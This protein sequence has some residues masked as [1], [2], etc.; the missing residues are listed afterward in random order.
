MSHNNLRV[1][2]LEEL[3]THAGTIAGGIA[4]SDAGIVSALSLA[5]NGFSDRLKNVF[6]LALPVPASA[7]T[8]D[9]SEFGITDVSNV[10][11][12]ECE[13]SPWIPV[14]WWEVRNHRLSI[15]GCDIAGCH[16]AQVQIEHWERPPDY[17]S[18]SGTLTVA[19]NYANAN[20]GEMHVTLADTSA[21]PPS[22]YVR[23]GESPDAQWFEYQAVYLSADPITEVTLL[24]AVKQPWA[25]QTGT[26]FTGEIVEWG[27]GF[28]SSTALD[29]LTKQAASYYWASKTGQC[30]NNDDR[31][32]ALN[33]LNFWT[34]EA[35]NAW[36]QVRPQRKP[37][38]LKKPYPGED[39][40]HSL[41]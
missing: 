41:Y 38:I 3:A 5:L 9:L 32:A 4:P 20:G 31:S 8:L 19:F 30:T 36:R 22:G 24:L 17:P 26:A 21:L 6:Y 33:L 40:C 13:S 10:W 37:V 34:G 25:H 1:L 11:W 35:Q 18:T 7:H 27:L 16:G 23:V 29:A 14:K 28:P 2:T 39:V 15:M 12:K